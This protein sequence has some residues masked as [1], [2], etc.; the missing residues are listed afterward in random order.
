MLYYKVFIYLKRMKVKFGCGILLFLCH[1]KDVAQLLLWLTNKSELHCSRNAKWCICSPV[2]WKGKLTF[3]MSELSAC[4]HLSDWLVVILSGRSSSGAACVTGSHESGKVKVIEEKRCNYLKVVP[5]I[6]FKTNESSSWTKQRKCTI[7]CMKVNGYLEWHH[8]DFPFNE[9][10]CSIA[11]GILRPPA[12][13]PPPPASS[14]QTF[15][16]SSVEVLLE[17]RPV[18]LIQPSVGAQSSIHSCHILI[19][20]LV[21]ASGSAVKELTVW[22]VKRPRLIHRDTFTDTQCNSNTKQ[23]PRKT[24][25]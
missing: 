14:P 23:L 4:F 3:T 22:G 10:W 7:F 19:L 21:S 16:E 15:S 20:S 5:S 24:L 8:K 17:R 18:S 11:A 25:F 12:L 6:V 2:K 9:G 13:T 1:D